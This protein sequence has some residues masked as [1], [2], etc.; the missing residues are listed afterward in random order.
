MNVCNKTKKLPKLNFAL[1]RCFRFSKILN[2]KNLFSSRE[3]KNSILCSGSRKL[4]KHVYKFELT[5]MPCVFSK[6]HSALF[7][8]IQG[9]GEYFCMMLTSLTSAAQT[10]WQVGGGQC[11]FAL[12]Q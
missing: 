4:A 3:E 11:E 7:S 8:D 10:G 12:R 6:D 1:L 2:L 9:G 5:V